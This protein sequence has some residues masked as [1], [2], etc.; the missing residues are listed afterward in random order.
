VVN[1]D[2][3]AWK[4]YPDGSATLADKEIESVGIGISGNEGVTV[5]VLASIACDETNLPL[6]V[7]VHGKTKRAEVSQLGNTKEHQTDHSL[8]GWSAIETMKQYLV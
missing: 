4:P 5:T 2:E 3:T 7:L 8:S 6:Y 1:C